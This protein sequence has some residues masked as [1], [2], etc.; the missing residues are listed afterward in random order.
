MDKIDGLTVE[1]TEWRGNFFFFL[2]S[3]RLFAASWFCFELLEPIGSSLQ[4]I[5]LHSPTG[6]Y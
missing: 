2:K 6:P 5:N 1:K 4:T 3:R